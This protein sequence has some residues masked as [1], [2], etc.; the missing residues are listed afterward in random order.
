[1]KAVALYS[2]RRAPAAVTVKGGAAR[3][4]GWFD[5][6]DQIDQF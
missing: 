1:V 5:Q 3:L 4:V 6:I 2:A